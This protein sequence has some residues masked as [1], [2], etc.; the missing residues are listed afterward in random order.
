MK[1]EREREKREKDT[2]KPP[3]TPPQKYSRLSTSRR[4]ANVLSLRG[5]VWRKV[6][7]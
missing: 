6:E 2:S 3:L 7:V 5:G 4:E 1:G